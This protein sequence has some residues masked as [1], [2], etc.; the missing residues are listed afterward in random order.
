MVLSFLL[1]LDNHT[2]GSDLPRR[3]W[4]LL[5]TV[6]G[7]LAT[8]DRLCGDVQYGSAAHRYNGDVTFFKKTTN[9]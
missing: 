2:S 4:F 6:T 8:K 9:F 5:P 7:E 3:Q 1:V